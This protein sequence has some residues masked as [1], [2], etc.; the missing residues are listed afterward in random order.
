MLRLLRFLTGMAC[1]VMRRAIQFAV[2]GY[3]CDHDWHTVYTE[4]LY[5]PGYTA[6]HAERQFQ[7][8]TKC[9]RTRAKKKWY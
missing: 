1:R 2:F 9:Q 4:Q 8:C 3:C 6:A 5:F 7:R